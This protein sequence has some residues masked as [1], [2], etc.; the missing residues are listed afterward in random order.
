MS[1]VNE[2][3]SA[4]AVDETLTCH[5]ECVHICRNSADL[6]RESLLVHRLQQLRHSNGLAL[7]RTQDSANGD[8]E[9]GQND[10]LRQGTAVQSISKSWTIRSRC[11]GNTREFGEGC[12]HARLSFVA[13]VLDAM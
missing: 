1:F 13:Q 5:R 2:S 9:D 7:D 8:G 11:P 6:E 10:T 4:T 3:S 12:S